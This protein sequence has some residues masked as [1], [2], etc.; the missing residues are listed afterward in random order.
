MFH[1]GI[2]VSMPFETLETVFAGGNAA[3]TVFDLPAGTEMSG[4][5]ITA[6]AASPM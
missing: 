3:P 1:G 6:P 4:I 2:Y 5:R